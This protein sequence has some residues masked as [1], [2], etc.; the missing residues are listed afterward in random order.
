MKLADLLKQSGIELGKLYTDK[1]LPPFKV[2]EASDK[3]LDYL[4]SSDKKAIE[5]SFKDLDH[6]FSDMSK[7]LGKA[8][9]KKQS[10]EFQKFYKKEWIEF[11]LK[12]DKLYKN[13]IG[14]K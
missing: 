13:N 2:N 7:D 9:Y 14:E 10:L 4:Y 11:K 3:D 6:W 5:K 12:F 1:D 8:G